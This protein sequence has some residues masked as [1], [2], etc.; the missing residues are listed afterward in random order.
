MQTSIRQS[1]WKEA[2]LENNKQME[3]AEVLLS[4]LLALKNPNDDSFNIPMDDVL[5]T[6]ET[7]ILL[8]RK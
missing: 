4:N 1:E 7:A 5:V 6:V 2:L 3:R 8:L